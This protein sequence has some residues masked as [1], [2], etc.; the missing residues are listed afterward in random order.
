MFKNQVPPTEVSG[1]YVLVVLSGHASLEFVGFEKGYIPTLLP[2]LEL[3]R[4]RFIITI[5]SEVKNPSRWNE[6][7]YWDHRVDAVG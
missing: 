7:L 2:E 4:E 3:K 5:L 1:V 6:L